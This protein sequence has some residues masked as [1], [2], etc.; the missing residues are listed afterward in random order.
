MDPSPSSGSEQLAQLVPSGA[1]LPAQNLL[2]VTIPDHQLL[3]CIGRGSYGGVWLA[4]ST[5][6]AYRAVKVVY[7]NSFETERP[8]DREW[9]GIRKFEP[10]SRSHEGFVD[11]LHIGINHEAGYFYY[12]ME[13]GDDE[14]SGQAID[15]QQYSPKTLATVIS[16]SRKLPFQD[17]LQFGMALSLALSELH[18]HGLV[19]RDIKPSNLIFV[20][21]VPKLAD[22]GLVAEVKAA[23]SYVG[24]EGFIP[25]EGPGTPQADVYG[26]GKV[27][28]EACTGKDR[29]DFPDLPTQLDE[30]PNYEQLLE[31]NEVILHACKN[32]PAKRYASAWDMHA[33]LVALAQR[34]IRPPAEGPGA[35]LG[36]PET[37]RR[38]LGGGGG[39]FVQL[40]VLGVSQ[41]RQRIGSQ[42]AADRR[43]DR[44]W[45]SGGRVG[46]SA[47]GLAAFCGRLAPGFNRLGARCGA[48]AAVGLRAGTIPE[49]DSFLVRRKAN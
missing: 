38:P 31:L 13:L 32:D 23:P 5:T 6:G 46:R 12:I 11:V 17:C 20:N 43:G 39:G 35:A 36:A 27:L 14:H 37:W 4:R 30:W 8:F 21:G 3:R 45:S 25:P 28:Y 16:Q 10:I 9:S 47:G 1:P 7:R 26:L 15:P 41:L 49:A 48:P 44:Q 19:H 34:Q 33:D 40:F 24:T 18:R 29:H 22:I 2:A 42:T